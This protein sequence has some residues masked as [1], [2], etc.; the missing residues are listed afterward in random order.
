MKKITPYVLLAACCLALTPAAAQQTETSTTPPATLNVDSILFGPDIKDRDEALMLYDYV[1]PDNWFYMLHVGAFLN[2]GSNQ[3]AGDFLGKFRPAIG[4]SLGKWFHPTVG[5]RAQVYLGNNRGFTN[6][7]KKEYHWQDA[8]V[9]IDGMVNLSNLL[10]GYREGRKF[11]FLAYLGM[12]GDQTFGFSKRDWNTDDSP[13]HYHRGAC[14]LL[15]FRAGAMGTWRISRKWDISL[16]MTNVWVDDSYDG[17]VT[18]NRWDGHVNVLLGFVRRLENRDSTHNFYYVR[19]DG[20]ILRN[21]NDE[22]NRLRAE[23]Q[24]LR[25]LPPL[26]PV[27]SQ[28]LHTIV[29]FRNQLS[30][31]DEMQ[32][33]NVYTAVQAMRQYDNKVNLYITALRPGDFTDADAADRQL[34]EE[35]ATAVRQ[36]LTQRYGVPDNLIVVDSNA[37]EVEQR[38]KQEGC[39]VVYINQSRTEKNNENEDR[40]LKDIQ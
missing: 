32:E 17:I 37:K 9:A 1:F 35:R 14:S 16:E 23:A 33:V 21:A 20:S 29:S 12:G 3:S 26:P 5:A 7:N 27:K 15:T 24:R 30:V 36:L 22:V 39:V 28:Q 8:G 40:R 34:F 6:A 11:N 25:D 2:W 13:D 4:I 18:N 38:D 10:L 31:I 19:R